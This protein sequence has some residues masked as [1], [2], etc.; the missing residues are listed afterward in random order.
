VSTTAF[1]RVVSED[2]LSSFLLIIRTPGIVTLRYP[3]IHG[4][5]SIQLDL[6]TALLFHLWF[7]KTAGVLT[8]I[9]WEG[10]YN[11]IEP[12]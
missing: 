9:R 2:P 11:E 1:Q 6:L 5:S 12:L 7:V 8:Y 3:G 10:S 4:C